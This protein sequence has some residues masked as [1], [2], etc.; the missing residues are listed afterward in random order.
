MKREVVTAMSAVTALGHGGV[1]LKGVARK[2][3]RCRLCLAGK[4]FRT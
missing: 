2:K 4:T 3:M 1:P